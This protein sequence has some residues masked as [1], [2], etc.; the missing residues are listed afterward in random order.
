MPRDVTVSFWPWFH[1]RRMLPKWAGF[2]FFLTLAV[3]FWTPSSWWL[4]PVGFALFFPLEY[5]THRWVY[6]FF[7]TRRAGSVLS[8]QHIAHHDTPQ[9][10]DYLFNDPRFGT[11]IGIVLFWVYFAITGSWGHAAALSAGNFSG[12]LYYEW[13]HLTAHRPGVRPIT[14]WNRLL[15]RSHLWHHFKNESY[16]YGVTTSVF[17]HT[18]RSHPDPTAVPMSPTVRTLVAPAEHEA[19]MERVRRD[20]QR[21]HVRTSGVRVRAGKAAV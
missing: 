12:F 2:L 7:A 14:P 1:H 21:G 10:L 16:W 6:H 4:L 3:L 19:V 8:K 5:V 20:N 9:D 13:V 11:L 18:F 15:K 17:D